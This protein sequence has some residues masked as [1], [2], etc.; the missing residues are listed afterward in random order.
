MRTSSDVWKMLLPACSC[1]VGCELIVPLC[2]TLGGKFSPFF[3]WVSKQLS[4]QFLKVPYCKHRVRIAGWYPPDVLQ[5]LDRSRVRQ[6]L[7]SPSFRTPRTQP[8]FFL[9]RA[10]MLSPYIRLSHVCQTELIE[11]V[12][13]NI[14]WASYSV[15]FNFNSFTDHAWPAW[16]GPLCKFNKVS[17]GIS[18]VESNLNMSCLGSSNALWSLKVK[19]LVATSLAWCPL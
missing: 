11:V 12:L 18:F 7:L 2:V 4:S 13:Y 10:F 15:E 5:R 8:A 3:A 6:F 14:T 19:E 1:E 16:L 9:L 17:K